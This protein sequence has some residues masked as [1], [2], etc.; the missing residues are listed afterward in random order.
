MNEK[1]ENARNHIREI[2]H[3]GIMEIKPKAIS[4]TQAMTECYMRGFNDCWE[5]LTGERIENDEDKD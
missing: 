2:L 3:K 4:A 1:I 5:L